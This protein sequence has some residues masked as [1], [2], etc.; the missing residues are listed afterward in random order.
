MSG[1]PKQKAGY[2]HLMIPKRIVGFNLGTKSPLTCS[3]SAVDQRVLLLGC[4]SRIDDY[5]IFLL[6]SFKVIEMFAI[7]LSKLQLTKI[8]NTIVIVEAKPLGLKICL[9]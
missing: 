2:N 8:E 4:Q 3:I 5:F 7:T 9:L 1:L 6:I